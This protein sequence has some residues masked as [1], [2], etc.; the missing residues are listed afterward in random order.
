MFNFFNKKSTNNDSIAPFQD[1]FTKL[2]KA[3][4]VSI[5]IIYANADG[6][7][8]PKEEEQIQ[9][10]VGLLN[11]SLSDPLLNE[12][13]SKG[14]QNLI[15]ILKTLNAGQKQWLLI[16]LYELAHCDGNISQIET[17][18]ALGIAK[19]IGFTEGQYLELIQKTSHLRKK[20]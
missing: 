19:D 15:N 12:L 2:Q 1:S 4:I 7:I 6:R 17:S 3:G 14:R 11:Y 8:N 16:S 5:L 20:Q 18:Y 10:T 13:P 9:N